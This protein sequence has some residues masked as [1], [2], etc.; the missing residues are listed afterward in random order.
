MRDR[1]IPFLTRVARTLRCPTSEATGFIL[2]ATEAY[3]DRAAT[4]YPVIDGVID[5]V[6]VT[7]PPRG[8]SQRLMESELVTR[9]Y[10]GMWRPALTSL[11][12]RQSVDEAIELSVAFL[13]YAPDA[14][15]LDIACGTGN[16]TRAIADRIDPTRGAAIGIDVSWPML[17][18]AERKRRAARLQHV[19]YAR[20]NGQSLPFD[21]Q[22]IDSVHCAGAFH[23]FEEKDRALEE[24]HR[25]L[26]PGGRL[27]LG[28]FI[29]SRIGVVRRAQL[30]SRRSTGFEF[31]HHATLL[32]KMRDLGFQHREEVIE[33]ASITLA[34][35]KL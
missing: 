3:C 35:E 11:V 24:F 27:V 29:E 25:V 34:A 19:M 28:T 14:V 6:G 9:V 4:R 16:F 33:G 15:V 18:A 13:N 1:D 8:I 23:L 17:R 26:A 32:Q 30:M 21:D 22:S 31:I 2:T 5:F 10:E 7:D 20:A 12:T